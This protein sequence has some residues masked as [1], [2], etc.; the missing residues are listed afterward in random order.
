[1]IG[2]LAERVA[3]GLCAAAL[4]AACGQQAVEAPVAVPESSP[5]AIIEQVEPQAPVRAPEVIVSETELPVA[6]DDGV[7]VNGWG[8]IR[9]GMTLEE[10]N[11]VL[12][13]PLDPNDDPSFEE[14]QCAILVPEGA[15]DGLVLMYDEQKVARI[16]VF[17]PGVATYGGLQVGDTAA[18][19]RGLLG[20]AV[21]AKQHFYSGA[22]AEYLTVWTKGGSTWPWDGP[23]APEHKQQMITS[24]GIRFETNVDG[25]ITR[26]H[27]G[28]G[29]IE[30]VEGCL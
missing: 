9:I 3:G 2:R 21:N 10:L 25:V 26:F 20:R 1:M 13:T 24:R 23:L 19:A 14:Y 11:A 30:K 22:P 29:A 15:P 28:D 16:D 7:T 12:K 8:K 5:A 17:E 6:P 4:L 27:A 18:K